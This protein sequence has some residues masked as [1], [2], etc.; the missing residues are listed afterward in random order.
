MNIVPK[1]ELSIDKLITKAL[2]TSKSMVHTN[3]SIGSMIKQV[4]AH[5]SIK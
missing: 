2:H 4:K 1:V 3:I 5:L